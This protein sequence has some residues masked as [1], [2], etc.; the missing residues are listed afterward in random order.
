MLTL[1]LRHSE[2]SEESG[3][4]VARPANRSRRQ[5]RRPRLGMTAGAVGLTALLAASSVHAQTT[6]TRAP[7]ILE[8]PASP[9]T[10]ALGNTG[11]AGRDDDVIFF[12]PAQVAVATGF[13]V[14]GERFSETA[15]A[16]ALSAVTRFNG[17]GIAVGMQLANYEQPAGVF[18]ATR[19]S[20]LDAGASASLSAEAVIA[21]AQAYKGTRLGVA[22]KYAE[23]VNSSTRL[24]RPLADVGLSRQIFGNTVGLAVQNIG[25]DM[26]NTNGTFIHLPV[27]TTLGAS[28]GTQAGPFDLFGTAA[29]SMLRDE[30]VDASGG[31]EVNYSWLNGYDIAVRAG[32]RRRDVGI[33]PLTL[34]AGLTMDRMSIDYA[35]ETLSN[36][37]VGH[38]I[39]VRIR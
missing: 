30:R 2:R 12:N 22:G 17:G 9:R 3:V 16:G 29:V 39:G 7:I 24:G 34:G 37:R 36:Q 32:V 25:R 33:E 11:V 10:L 4:L 8:L 35:L 28:R 18:P 13:S 26:E 21:Y 23:D 19:L 27:L 14:S 15:G 1:Q 31:V 6:G 38:R 5:I 20:L